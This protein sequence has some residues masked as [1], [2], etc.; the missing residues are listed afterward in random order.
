MTDNGRSWIE[1]DLEALDSNIK[2][3]RRK[4]D[5]K[6]KL[7]AIVKDNAY[8]MGIDA[9]VNMQKQSID[10]FA[11]SYLDEAIEL[12]KAGITQNI[13]ILTKTDENRIGEVFEFGLIQ[14]IHSEGYAQRISRIC[15]DMKIQ[16][17]CHLKIDTGMNR[18]GIKVDAET[19]DMTQAIHIFQL[20]GI[21]IDG[22]FTH[23][24]AADEDSSL[25]KQETMRQINLFDE[26]LKHL[27]E[28]RI[29]YGI[30]HV[31]NS[32][33]FLNYREYSYDYVRIGLLLCGI[34]GASEY[35]EVLSVKSRITMVKEIAKG[36]MIGYGLFV[37]DRDNVRI[38]TL[39]IGYGDGIAR[40][41]STT[42]YRFSLNEYKIPLIGKVCMD[43]CMVDVTGID[44]EENDIVTVIGDNSSVQA[45][46]DALNTIPNE[47]LVRLNGR[48]PRYYKPAKLESNYEKQDKRETPSILV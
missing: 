25:G 43:Q 17:H 18:I 47:I 30:T 44:C 20:K 31:L 37:N 45:M 6:S 29:N 23:L 35:K 9:V 12:R 11:V 4:L 1:V 39:S 19:M 13:L 32:A 22:I 8:G 34:G 42:N 26:V 41:L 40:C 5:G 36:E 2:T 16:L 15:L 28:K 33:G 46:A 24:H 10:F 7:M 3:I 21:K 38:A 14:T 48:L 27:K